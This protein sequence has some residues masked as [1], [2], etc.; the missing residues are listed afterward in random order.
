MYNNKKIG[1]VIAAAGKGSRMEMDIPKQFLKV[2]GKPVIVKTFQA[3]ADCDLVDNIY[4]VT[5]EKYMK[6]CRDLMV[7]YLTNRQLNKF[8]GIVSGGEQRQDS[9]YRALQAIDNQNMGIDYILIHDGARPFVSQRIIEH[10]I[11]ASVQ[12]DVAIVCVRPKDTIRTKTETLN[13]DELMAVQTPQGFRYDILKAAYEKA[14]EDGFYGT[15]D[16]SLVEKLGV[17]PVFVEGSYAN[18]KITTRED[19]PVETRIGKG[20]DVHKLVEDRKCILGGVEIP[21]KKGLLG[22]SDADV[23]L[24]A[25]M[26]AILGAAAMGDIGR[27][28]PDTDE[29]YKGANSLEL[30]EQVGYMV[31]EQGYSISNIDAT[32][33]CERPKISP[34]VEQ[35][36]EKIAKTLTIDKGQINIKGT[37]T[38]KLGFTGRKEGIAAEAVCILKSN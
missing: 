3:F 10:T 13:R 22:H 33:V 9:I 23:L 6:W 8:T 29:K 26:D 34:Y 19:L 24:H 28:F 15:D 4:V 31:R 20:F 21:Y 37:T 1:V 36:I 2:S 11:A 32:V 5:D 38:E 12:N 7:P 30:L 35:M 17:C 25:I 14:Y 27:H 18:I 16:A